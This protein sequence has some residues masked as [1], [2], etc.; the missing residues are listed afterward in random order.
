MTGTRT[1]PPPGKLPYAHSYPD[2]RDDAPTFP[3]RQ[4][5]QAV[6]ASAALR[7][8]CVDRLSR[9]PNSGQTRARL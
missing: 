5:A 3:S 8:C 9:H 7:G 4:F 2:T 1:G 6:A